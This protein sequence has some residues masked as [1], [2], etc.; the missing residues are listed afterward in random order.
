M[1]KRL[2]SMLLLV[3]MIVT[4]LPLV[5]FPITATETEKEW[6]EEDYNAFYVTD[7]ALMIADFFTL[8]EYWG[9]TMTFPTWGFRKGGSS[10]V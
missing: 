8:N 7:G 3:A 6:T 1:K 5:A 10:N 9:G 2:L 4:A